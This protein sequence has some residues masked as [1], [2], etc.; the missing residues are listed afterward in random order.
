[1]SKA[2]SSAR[3]ADKETKLGR[4]ASALYGVEKVGS[5]KREMMRHEKRM[6]DAEINLKLKEID[7]ARDQVLI[8]I[9]EFLLSMDIELST[10]V[11]RDQQNKLDRTTGEFRCLIK[12]KE[13]I[14]LSDG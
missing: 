10:C 11:S 2:K 1:M 14:G 3:G 6:R 8:A 5:S 13:Q 4:F 12:E 9:A 7:R